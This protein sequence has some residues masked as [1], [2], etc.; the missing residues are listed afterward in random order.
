LATTQLPAASRADQGREQQLRRIVPGA[1]H[2]DHAQRFEHA[3][4]PRSVEVPGHRHGL[5]PDP[6]VQVGQGVV[7]LTDG[8]D[9]LGAYRLLLALAEVRVE[10]GGELGLAVREQGAQCGQLPDPP[11]LVLRTAGTE[12]RTQPRDGVDGEV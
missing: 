12:R 6:V 1:D 2:E 11:V 8:E 4:G 7:Y 10:R 9:D 5:G 3:P